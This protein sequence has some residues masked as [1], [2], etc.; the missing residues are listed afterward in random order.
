MKIRS[1]EQGAGSKTPRQP[2]KVGRTAFPQA[3]PP[4]PKLR[5]GKA[6]PFPQAER[7]HHYAE[8]VLG[9][10]IDTGRWVAA[11]CRRHLADLEHG[12]A[13]GLIW[14]PER[15]EAWIDFFEK[16]LCLEPGRPFKLEDFQAFQVGNIFGWQRVDE[17]TGK[18]RRRFR[19]CYIEEGKGNGKTPMLAGFGLGG[20]LIDSEKSPEVFAAA[21]SKEQMKKLCF[22][23]AV[24]MVRASP[25]LKKRLVVLTNNISYP[26][27]TGS[28]SILSSEDGSKHGLRVHM[29]LL[30]EIHAHA[31]AAMVDVVE[32][33][34][35][36]C[37]NSLIALLTN[38]GKSQ[39]GPCWAYHKRALAMLRGYLQDRAGHGHPGK[40]DDSL[41]AYVCALDP[42]PRCQAAGKQQPDPKCKHCDDWKEEKH[43][44]KANP[45]LG[46]I[47]DRDYIKRRVNL[48]RTMPSK[49]N[50]VLQLNFCTWTQTDDGW[51]DMFSWRNR[52]HDPKLKME[53]FKG[54]PCWVGMDAANRVDCTCVA[55][56]FDLEGDGGGIDTATLPEAARVALAEAMGAISDEGTRDQAGARADQAA[57][58]A[59]AVA[60]LEAAGYALFLRTYVPEAMVDN[61]SQANYEAY[62]LWKNEGWLIVTPG[63]ITDFARIEQDLET[64]HADH[65][66]QRLQA[67]PRELGYLLQRVMA[68][69]GESVVVQVSQGPIMISQPMKYFEGLN[70]AGLIK[71]DGNPVLD[72]MLGNVVQK[73]T[74]TG[75]PVK[76]YYPTRPSEEKKIDGAP[77]SFMALD[78]R[79]RAPAAPA[80]PGMVVLG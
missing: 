26:A 55:I 1:K 64:L 65:P 10:D 66:I 27:K 31:T 52:C 9:G 59:E 44:I 34:T 33:G 39:Q 49:L 12:P 70:A 72:F 73:T 45:G 40:P 2:K 7:V 76:Y 6:H 21:V 71:H 54:K 53:R 11:A 32:A 47:L 15:A 19:E 57:K 5:R 79:L 4:S 22:K 3:D 62:Q 74:R 29:G 14:K 80:A 68:W 56:L 41:F 60:R 51:L 36:N 16:T 24:Q 77:A 18:L 50:S 38:S 28:F 63:A 37:R 23:D 78:G 13:R 30:D 69:L 35:K 46:T 20:L 48:A 67:D 8:A 75:G 17:A 25:E 61:A 43:W 58:L 42:C